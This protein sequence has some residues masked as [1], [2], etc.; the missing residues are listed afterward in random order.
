LL[1]ILLNNL[2]QL[3]CLEWVCAGKKVSDYAIMWSAA[4]VSL[5]TRRLEAGW[6]T[7][8]SPVHPSPVTVK[9]V[10]QQAAIVLCKPV[11]KQQRM[12]EVIYEVQK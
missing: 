4:T 2:W 9:L 3:Q 10:L 12:Q 11:S 6:L 1:E 8:Q 5:W 7:Q